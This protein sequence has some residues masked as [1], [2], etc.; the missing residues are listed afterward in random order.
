[1]N[2]QVGIKALGEFFERSKGNGSG[3]GI[4]IQVMPAEVLI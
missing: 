3:N 2:S 1:M 4:V